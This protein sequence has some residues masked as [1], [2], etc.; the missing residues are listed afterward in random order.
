[1]RRVLVP[2]L[3]FLLPAWGQEG[4]ASPPASPPDPP[5]DTGTLVGLKEAIQVIAS[6]RYTV[7]AYLPLLVSKEV[8]STLATLAKERGVRV[9]VIVENRALSMPS[10]YL[11]SMVILGTRYPI[12]V[13]VVSNTPGIDPRVIVDR[14]YLLVGGALEG[15]DSLLSPTLLFRD[16]AYAQK[17]LSRFDRTWQVAPLCRPRIRYTLETRRLE[18]GCDL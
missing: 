4:N 1:M 12:Q 16:P 10:T 18:L 9:R 17:E 3:F 11:Y 14:S 8:A 5:R 6:A 13:K 2:I 7:D 15:I